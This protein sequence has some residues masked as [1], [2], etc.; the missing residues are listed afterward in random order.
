MKKPIIKT[1]LIIAGVLAF[2]LSVVFAFQGTDFSAL[3]KASPLH[4]MGLGIGVVVNLLLTCVLF[5]AVTR[6]FD[7]EPKVGIGRMV[8]LILSSSVLNYLPL[9][10][11]LLGRAAYLKAVHQLPLKQS[12]LILIIVLALGALVL[13]SVGLAVVSIRQMDQLSVIILTCA[14]LVAMSPI[15]KRLLSKLAMRKLSEAQVLGWL[16]IRMTDMFMVGA[17]TWFAFAICGNAISF[18]QATAL[19]AAGMLISLL[20]L[21]PNGLGLREW[22]I[23]G[24]TLMVSDHDASAGATA[25]LVDR[26]VEVVVVC[27]LGLPTS[28]Y[29]AKQM[30]GIKSEENS[31]KSTVNG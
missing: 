25:A 21:T 17:R 28:W 31:E 15:W 23:A 13:G 20:G 2:A 1:I 19:G 3:R 6:P 18:A 12:G 4:V 27:L 26:A 11:G 24:M 8:A 5:W 10:M 29:L 9:R 30:S 16:S 7:S 22:A 14:L